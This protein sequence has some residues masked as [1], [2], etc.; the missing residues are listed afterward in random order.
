MKWYGVNAEQ[1]NRE[2]GKSDDVTVYIFAE[3]IEEVI[4]K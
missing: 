3:G 2:I 4:K 1:F